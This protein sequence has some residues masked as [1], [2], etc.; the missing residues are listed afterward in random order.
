M[1]T[2]YISLK[3]GKVPQ[4]IQKGGVDEPHLPLKIL[5]NRPTKTTNTDM[6]TS[7]QTYSQ[8]AYVY[9]LHTYPFSLWPS[10]LQTT[11]DFCLP[12]PP[13]PHFFFKKIA[14]VG[15]KTRHN[16]LRNRFIALQC[17]FVIVLATFCG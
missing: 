2:E 6:Y 15:K 5:S 3:F 10:N 4:H 17:R 8:S 12:P 13:P 1:C 14:T 11:A 7:M 16:R 9:S